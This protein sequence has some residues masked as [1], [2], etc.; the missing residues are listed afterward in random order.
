MRKLI[1]IS[2]HQGNINFD[3]VK[4][5]GV[6]GVIIRAGFGRNNIDEKFYKNIEGCEKAGLPVGIYWFSYAYSVGMAANEALYCLDAIKG[7]KITLP[8]FF[9]WEYDSNDYAKKKGVRATE[10]L[11]TAMTQAFCKSISDAGYKAGY[12]LNED[13]RLHMID[14]TK[15]GRYHSWYAR[16]NATVNP[17]GYDI[18][19]YSSKGKVKGINGD[20][21][22]DWLVNDSL[23][24]SIEPA[25][26]KKTNEEIASE[27]LLGIWGTGNT[28]KQRILAAGYDYDA[29]QK[30]VNSKMDKTPKKKSN[31]EIAKEVKA[32]LW[33]NGNARKKKLA[34]AGYDYEA[35][36]QLVN[37]L[38]KK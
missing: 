4:A 27:V 38:S 17:S 10:T 21:D 35:I 3:A 5:D 18:W 11:V 31:E 33:G 24:G 23:L 15:L 25:M 16:Y 36:R 2:K 13:Y 6:D 28:R 19:Q 32:G 22:L 14:E 7:H 8:I 30:I 26:T 29:I 20:V 34:A 37:K 1:D 9:D 12:Y